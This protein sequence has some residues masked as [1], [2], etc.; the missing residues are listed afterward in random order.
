[1]LI[2]ILLLASPGSYFIEG[3]SQPGS[4]PS[5][6]STRFCWCGKV[7]EC[8]N[9]WRNSAKVLRGHLRAAKTT[10]AER[11]TSAAGPP[12]SS[13][14]AATRWW[15]C[16]RKTLLGTA[17][18]RLDQGRAQSM[19]TASMPSVLGCTAEWA[20]QTP[21]PP[22]DSSS[23]ARLTKRVLFVACLTL[24]LAIQCRH[25]K[26]HLPALRKNVDGLPKQQASSLLA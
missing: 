20:A 19:L 22:P 24:R 15:G 16:F 3:C 1:M 10:T 26:A 23:A 2:R 4:R 25:G 12:T 14:T 13:T 8:R 21:V 5:I 11:C 9:F 18:K 6:I 17:I 7:L